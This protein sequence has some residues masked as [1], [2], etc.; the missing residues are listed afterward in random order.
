VVLMFGIISH[1]LVWL[2]ERAE[3]RAVRK[4]ERSFPS[5]RQHAPWPHQDW[6]GA[7]A[8]PAYQARPYRPWPGGD[9]Q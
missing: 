7:G 5:V 6:P 2:D 9:G 8:G 3:R 1:L 4:L